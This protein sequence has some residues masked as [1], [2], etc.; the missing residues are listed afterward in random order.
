VKNKIVNNYTPQFS[1]P[2]I[3]EFII[4]VEWFCV[5]GDFNQKHLKFCTP[6]SP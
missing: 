6:F 1:F 2:K 3:E 5:G 4:V